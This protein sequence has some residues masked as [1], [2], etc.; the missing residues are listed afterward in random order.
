MNGSKPKSGT[1]PGGR[2]LISKEE[3]FKN[4]GIKV[5]VQYVRTDCLDLAC[6]QSLSRAKYSKGIIVQPMLPI[7]AR[8]SLVAIINFLSSNPIHPF[9]IPTRIFS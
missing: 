5:P 4:P 9:I 7:F 3:M 1:Q 2:N 6:I 8:T